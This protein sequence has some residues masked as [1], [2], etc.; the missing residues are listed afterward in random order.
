MSQYFEIHPTH[1]Q[2]RLVR[3]AAEIVRR[4]G[5]I[6]CPTDSTYAFGCHLG[7]KAALD[8]IRALRKLDRRHLLTLVC[9]DLSVIASYAQVDNSQYRLLRRF[10]P[11]PYTFVLQASRE[12]P[13]RLLQEGRKTIGLRVPEHPV[14]LALLAELGEPMLSTTAALPP[15]NDPL[16]DAQAIR[17]RLQKRVELVVDAGACGTESTTIVDLTLQPPVILRKGLGDW[18]E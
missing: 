11:G 17:E 18:D 13:K 10:T 4:G 6:C 16:D 8:R 9:H 15:D 2:A 5:V 1:P 12:V 14:T 7:D 3:Q